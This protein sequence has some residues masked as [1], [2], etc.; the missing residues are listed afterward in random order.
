MEPNHKR[1]AS[2]GCTWRGEMQLRGTVRVY[3][4]KFVP[5]SKHPFPE[6]NHASQ[7][8]SL[9]GPKTSPKSSQLDILVDELPFLEPWNEVS[10]GGRGKHT[11]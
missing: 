3:G 7:A 6:L 11:T 9:F 10:A 5:M 8:S 2:E 4:D 1:Y